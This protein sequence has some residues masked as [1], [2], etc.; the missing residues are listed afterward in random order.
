MLLFG[1]VFTVLFLW[2][3]ESSLRAYKRGGDESGATADG[4]GGSVGVNELDGLHV[5]ATG[6][7]E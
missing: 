2:L 5:D 6:I 1:P 4:D 3:K 7:K